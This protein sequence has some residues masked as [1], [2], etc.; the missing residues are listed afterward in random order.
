VSVL[1][2]ETDE[3]GSQAADSAKH[4]SLTY[5]WFLLRSLSE[6]AFACAACFGADE[7]SEDHESYAADYR[8]SVAAERATTGEERDQ[9]A[10]SGRNAEDDGEG[11][12]NSDSI[13]S[14]AK[15]DLRNSPTRTTPGGDEDRAKTGLGIDG[16]Q[17]WHG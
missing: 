11:K 6:R 13:Y 10:H 5:R 7:H 16:T 4:Q 9:C 12:C 17:R 15:E 2:T 14:Q 1:Q 8:Q 3:C